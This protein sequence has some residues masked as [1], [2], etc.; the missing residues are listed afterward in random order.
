MLSLKRFRDFFSY[1]HKIHVY[2][3]SYFLV[4]KKKHTLLFVTNFQHMYI[5]HIKN[6]NIKIHFYDTKF[7]RFEFLKSS[8]YKSN[9]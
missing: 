4:N 8:T 5:I 7:N 1:T 9:Q 2:M 6:V 3:Q